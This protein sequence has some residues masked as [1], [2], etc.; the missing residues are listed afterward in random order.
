MFLYP[1]FPFTNAPHTKQ[2]LP[3]L[4]TKPTYFCVQ[5]NAFNKQIEGREY[6]L[7]LKPTQRLVLVSGH[8]MAAE[9]FEESTYEVSTVQNEDCGNPGKLEETLRL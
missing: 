8:L 3:S 9:A 5:T 6:L 7:P 4:P 2:R 1:V